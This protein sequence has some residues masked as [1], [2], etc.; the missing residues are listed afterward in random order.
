MR[1]KP[2]NPWFDFEGAGLDPKLGPDLK[3]KTKSDLAQLF[4]GH[5]GRLVHKW[6][7]YLDIYDRHF[8]PFRDRAPTMLEIGVQNGGSLEMWR[9]YFG[10]DAT[11]FGVDIDP[12]CA[13]RVTPPNQVRIGSQADAAFLKSVAAEMGPLDIVLDDGSHIASH[14][15]ESFRVLFPLLKDGGLYVLEDLHTAYLPGMHEGGYKRSGSAIEFVKQMIDDMHAWYHG[16]RPKT[17]AKTEIVGIHVYDSIIFLE[18]GRKEPPHHI[19]IS[20]TPAAA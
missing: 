18:K 8:G 3:A 15:R 13:E 12:R 10:P 6:T 9:R 20:G 2:S 14:Q 19:K 1:G 5:E 4:Y 11:I 16:H 17:P 7:H